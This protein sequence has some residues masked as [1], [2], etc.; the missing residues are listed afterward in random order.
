MRF[1]IRCAVAIAMF[2]A[3]GCMNSLRDPMGKQDALEQAQRRY[4]ELVR[5]GEI[6]TASAFVDPAIAETYLDRGALFKDVRFT[7]FETGPIRMDEGANT[8]TINVVYRAYS[9]RTLVEKTIRER[10]QWYRDENLAHE[11]KVRPDFEMPAGSSSDSS[12]SSSSH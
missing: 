4:T 5:W 12:S 1:L 6:E 10:Q 7:D 3:L 11:W 9:T 8:A 2:A